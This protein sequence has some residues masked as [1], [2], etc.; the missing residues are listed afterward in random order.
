VSFHFEST[1]QPVLPL[2]EVALKGTSQI[3]SE[4]AGK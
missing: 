2:L 3:V 1:G 4:L